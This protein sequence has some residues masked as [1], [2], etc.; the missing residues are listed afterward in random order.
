MQWQAG[1]RMYDGKE[2]THFLSENTYHRSTDSV[3]GS[4]VALLDRSGHAP[5]FFPPKLTF[6]ARV[7]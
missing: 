1:L 5:A 2:S 4:V 3:H 7:S 6:A